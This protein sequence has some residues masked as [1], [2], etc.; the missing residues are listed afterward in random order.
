MVLPNSLGG[1]RDR[2][3]APTYVRNNFISR[4]LFLIIFEIRDIVLT[5]LL[6]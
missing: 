2:N 3:V 5:G 6:E 1:L 4:R